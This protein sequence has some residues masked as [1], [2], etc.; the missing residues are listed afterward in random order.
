MFQPTHCKYIIGITCFRN[1]NKTVIGDACFQVL[2]FHMKTSRN[3]D[4]RWKHTAI[5]THSFHNCNKLTI[6]IRACKIHRTC[7][8]PSDNPLITSN[9][10]PKTSFIDIITICIKNAMFSLDIVISLKPFL[11]IIIM[12]CNFSVNLQG[13]FLSKMELGMSF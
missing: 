11:R 1:T 4:A 3:N 13:F 10:N 8:F 6:T 12:M 9:T 7:G 2:V 5:P